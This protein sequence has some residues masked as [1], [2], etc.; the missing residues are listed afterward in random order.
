[1]QPPPSTSSK[2]RRKFLQFAG[3]TSLGL[4]GVI[5]YKFLFANQSGETEKSRSLPNSPETESP[6]PTPISPETESPTPTPISRSPTKPA[7]PANNLS[8]FSFEVVT[9]NAKGEIINRRNREAIFF[10]ENINNVTLEMVSIPGGTFLMGAPNTEKESNSNEQPQRK[11]TVA[12]FFMGKYPVTQA[13]WQ[14]VASLPKIKIPLQAN[15]AYFKGANRPVEQ[16]SWNEIQEFC[17]R[18]SQKTGKTY[19]LPSEA[20]WEYA[21]RARTTTPFYFG[22][23]ITPNL[24]NYNGNY[25]YDSAPRGIFRRQTTNVGSFPPNAFGLYDMHGN[26]W[27]WCTDPWHENYRGAPSDGR[28]WQG[29][30]NQDNQ[31]RLIRGG[32]WYSFPWACRSAFRDGDEL[33]GKYR[34]YGFRV[35]AVSL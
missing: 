6:T 2:T 10:K 29:G 19:R 17:A 33:D 28:V 7:T 1:M 21:C 18:L 11:V 24:V 30:D 4:I 3:F 14:A 23:T 31:N 9:V 27:E 22:K 15:P 32:S 13:Q 25:T 34:Y 26:V 5:V 20:E 12:S 35:V 16:V 8:K